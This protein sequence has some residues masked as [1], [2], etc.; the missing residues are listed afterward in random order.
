MKKPHNKTGFS[1]VELMMSLGILVVGRSM[2]ATTFPTAM[3]ANK[4]SVADTSA[5]MISENA[6]AIC[7]AK[8][9][10]DAIKGTVTAI[11]ENRGDT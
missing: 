7:Q 10:H 4:L 8:L 1:L 5:T 6:A 3:M 9:S 11:L 2:V